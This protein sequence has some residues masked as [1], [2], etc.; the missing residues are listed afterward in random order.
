MVD[1]VFS[2]RSV[3]LPRPI[4]AVIP[5]FITR[6]SIIT[7]WGDY[8]TLN[9]PRF[10]NNCWNAKCN[11]IIPFC[12]NGK[13]CYETGNHCSC[14]PNQK[15]KC[16]MKIHSFLEGP[17]SHFY[18]FG[19][20]MLNNSCYFDKNLIHLKCS[21]LLHLWHTF[22]YLASV[23]TYF[24]FWYW[25]SQIK[26]ILASQIAGTSLYTDL[27]DRQSI[28]FNFYLSLMT[29]KIIQKR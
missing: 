5:V 2:S 22:R 8:S 23:I 11:V 14:W 26:W 21:H 24:C 17:S 29:Y 20:Q 15:T 1:A 7:K 18:F 28:I 27:S 19:K 16:K 6:P 3:A 10:A 12:D 9:I 4:A 25:K 13:P